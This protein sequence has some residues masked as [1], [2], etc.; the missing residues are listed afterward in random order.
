MRKWVVLI[1]LLAVAGFGTMAWLVFTGP[2]MKSQPHLR[3]YQA[4]MPLPPPESVPLPAGLIPS[5]RETAQA[6]PVADTPENRARGR[7]YYGY[8]CA[9]CHGANG[10]GNGTV[11]QSYIPRPAD[12]RAGRARHCS[13]EEI[14]QLMLL[15]V[16]HEPVLPRAVLPAHRGYLALYVHA[17]CADQRD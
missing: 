5:P 14:V 3:T 8:Y 7:V 6:R 16:G 4:L 1:A 17:L 10:D 15:G 11:G 2:R 9:F 13:Q 12:L